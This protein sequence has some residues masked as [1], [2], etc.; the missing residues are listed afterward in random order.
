MGYVS[1][2]VGYVRE[3][4]GSFRPSFAGLERARRVGCALSA[5]LVGRRPRSQTAG[6]AE[7]RELEALAAQPGKSMLRGCAFPNAKG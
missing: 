3:C 7:P 6:E 5:G 2:C 1:Q 4:V